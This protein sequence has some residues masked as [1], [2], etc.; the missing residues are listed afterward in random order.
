MQAKPLLLAE[1]EAWLSSRARPLR[2]RIAQL[3]S[4]HDKH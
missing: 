1:A 3:R 4:Q 2:G